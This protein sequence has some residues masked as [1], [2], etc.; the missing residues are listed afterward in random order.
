VQPSPAPTPGIAQRVFGPS[1]PGPRTLWANSGRRA[2][3]AACC[4]ALPLALGVVLGRPDLGSA[5]GL[6]G[7]T[8]IY[9]HALPFRRRAVVVAG[10]GAGLLAAF[11][12][13]ALVGPHPLLLAPVL[14]VLVAAA[15]AATAVW[16]LGPPGPLG[17][18]LVGGGASA[19]GTTPGQLGPHLLAAAGG[20]LLSWLVC[21]L[22]WLWDPHGPERRAVAAAEA[23]VAAAERGTLR[24]TRPD[25]A[26]HAVRVAH[27]AVADG[28]RRGGARPRTALAARLLGIEERFFRALPH[29]DVPLTPARLERVAEPLGRRRWWSAPWLP[30]ALRV[31]VAAAV[32]GL[33]AV[34]L[35]LSSSYW[36]STSAVAVLLGADV[37]ATRARAAHRIVGTLLGIG[38]AAGLLA[39]GLPVGV[40]VLLVG[41]L[42]MTVELLIASQ[43]VLAVSAIT[44]LALL[45]VHVG[46]PA[47]P[48]PELIGT[49]L[50]ETLV[51]I[52]V[53][54]AA[55]FLLFRRAAS[56]RLP[57]AVSATGAL[58]LAAADA[59]ADRTGD[60]ALRDALVSLYEV[61]SASRAEL[62]PA[63]GTGV[64]LRRSRRAADLGWALLGARAQDEPRLAAQVAAAIR[65]DLG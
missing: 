36:A 51:G 65:T 37:R 15:A 41:L 11:G 39:V 19:L 33:L 53:A 18:V 3:S 2:L 1:P 14:G 56:R 52:A 38:I 26:A 43:Y 24:S 8:A 42:Q 44:P 7:F 30:G 27:A 12:L 13:G 47:R 20:V 55:G 5:A 29:G 32:A 57:A 28:S 25:P 60:R 17:A 49:R 50:A 34:A 48:V 6:A 63:P 10:V 64:W 23:A 62:S 16:R 9:G 22:P 40:Q 61:A 4:V 35:G 54:L 59:G 46:N 45:L 21:M 58:V 31:G